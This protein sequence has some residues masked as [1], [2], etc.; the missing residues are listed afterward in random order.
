MFVPSVWSAE[1]REPR[2][3]QQKAY[4]HY[5]ARYVFGLPIPDFMIEQPS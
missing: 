5:L 1:V 4:I 2:S 3:N